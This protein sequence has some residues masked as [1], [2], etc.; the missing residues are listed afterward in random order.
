LPDGR[1]RVALTEV[2][3]HFVD[4]DEW[5]YEEN[6]TTRYERVVDS[7]EEVEAAVREAGAD[8]DALDVPWRNDCPF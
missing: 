3:K 4:N 8:P 2:P 1:Y 6:V 7:V 5:F